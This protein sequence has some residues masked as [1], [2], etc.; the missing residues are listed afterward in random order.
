MNAD[1]LRLIQK[2]DRLPDSLLQQ[3]FDFV[4]FL[5]WKQKAD[6]QTLGSSEAVPTQE[7]SAWLNSDLSNLGAIESYEWDKGEL[8]QGKAISYVPRKGLVIEERSNGN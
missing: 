6:T 5:L 4:D 7:D 8:E 1:K 3:V 2:I